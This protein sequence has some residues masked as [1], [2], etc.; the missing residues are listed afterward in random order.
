MRNTNVTGVYQINVH[1]T[2]EDEPMILW[3]TQPPP[4]VETVFVS[5][6]ILISFL[7][8]RT[9]LTAGIRGGRVLLCLLPRWSLEPPTHQH[10]NQLRCLYDLRIVHWRPKLYHQ[11][12]RIHL[13]DYTA[14]SYLAADASCNGQLGCLA[15]VFRRSV[16]YN[17]RLPTY[18]H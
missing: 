8:R 11:S 13:F 10:N 16:P 1:L 5:S 2:N 4:T 18:C 14:G 15:P 17:N 6:I 12:W 3:P 9:R 7:V